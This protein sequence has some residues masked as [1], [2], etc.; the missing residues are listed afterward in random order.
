M[1]DQRLTQLIG[2]VYN[3]ALDASRWT[4]QGN[5]EMDPS[6]PR[7]SSTHFKEMQGV[8]GSHCCGSA[9]RRRL[10]ANWRE[11][12]WRCDATKRKIVEN[13]SV[14]RRFQFSALQTQIAIGLA[15]C[16]SGH[17]MSC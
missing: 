16:R 11:L 6:K 8:Q 4:D 1:E 17:E 12:S 13:H 2:D 9:G 3:A 5:K 7:R 14:P 10:R 15:T